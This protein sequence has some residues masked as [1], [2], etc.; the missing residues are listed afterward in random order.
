MST[1]GPASAD[2]ARDL[3]IAVGRIARRIRAIYF[4]SDAESEASF[5]E[6]SVLS[7]LAREGSTTASELAV[8]EQITPQGIGTILTRLHQRGL[9]ARSPDPHDRRR[10]ITS[11]T[12]AGRKAL[13]SRHLA[14]NDAL[15][16]TLRDQFKADELRR[17]TAVLPLLD[18]LG[19]RL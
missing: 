1:Q 10:I 7:R 14:V 12:P 18:R 16:T 19:D 13:D 15:A 17:L 3:R 5:G 8:Q 6:I 4:S 9:V 2:L 11:I